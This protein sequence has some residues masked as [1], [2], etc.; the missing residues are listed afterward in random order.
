MREVTPTRKWTLL[1]DFESRKTKHPAPALFFLKSAR[2]GA[3]TPLSIVRPANYAVPPHRRHVFVNNRDAAIA[4]NAAHFVQHESR[5]L[6]VMQHVAEQHSVEALVFD[7][8]MA[9]IVREIIDARGGV[10]ADVES[11]HCGPQQS[12]QMMRDEAIAA[13]DVEHVRSRRQHTGDFKRHVICST[14]LAASSHALEATFDGCS[15]TDH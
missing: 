8:K 7:W 2:S 1:H 13:A 9:T 3:A 11:N 5:I 15:Q 14:H 4:Q 6:C 12:L 10:V